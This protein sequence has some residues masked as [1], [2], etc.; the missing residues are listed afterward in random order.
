MTAT[1]NEWFHER[2]NLAR[3]GWE[4]VVDG[5][6]PGWAHTG[7]RVAKLSGEGLTLP[8]GDIERIVVPLAGGVT[9]EL[10]GAAAAAWDGASSVELTG[11]ASVFDG[12]TDVL[13]VGAGGGFTVRGTARIAIAEAPTGQPRPTRYIPAADV[14]VEVRGAGRDT[15]QVHN[16][17][18]PGALDAA[19]LIVCEVITPGGNWSSHPAHKHDEHIAGHESRLEE[20]YYFEA[21]PNREFVAA[22]VVP[23]DG[24]DAFGSFV[25]YSSRAG[26]IDTHAVVRTGDI[27]LVPYGYHGPAMAAPEYDLY[28]L[29]VMAGPDPERV[30]LISDDPRQAWLRDTWPAQGPDPRLPYAAAPIEGDER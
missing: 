6:L 25:T 13:Y 27:A 24:V 11:R 14:P 30:W 1:R 21:A 23:D 29:N 8:A 7:I 3:D 12:P 5:S 20:I 16:F 18:T 9:V 2:G 19:A 26:E 10:D 17:G 4:S 15:R 28:Y 22:G